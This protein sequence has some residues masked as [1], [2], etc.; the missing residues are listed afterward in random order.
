[1]GEEGG[2]EDVDG[3]EAVEEEAEEPE[4]IRLRISPPPQGCRGKEGG[5]K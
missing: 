2:R 1:M 5:G 4:I 3:D